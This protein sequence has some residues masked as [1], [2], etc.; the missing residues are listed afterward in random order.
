MRLLA[1]NFTSAATAAGPSIRQFF[2][3]Q[4]RAKQHPAAAQQ[5]AA[6]RQRTA[7]DSIGSGL[8][9]E[10]AAA[11][12]LAAAARDSRP[13]AAACGAAAPAQLMWDAEDGGYG[14]ASPVSTLTPPDEDCTQLVGD[15]ADQPLLALWQPAAALESLHAAAADAGGIRGGS[16]GGSD[17]AMANADSG[18][19]TATEVAPSASPEPS[20]Q[21]VDL[22]GIDVSEQRRILRQLQGGGGR[23]GGRDGK[24]S[25]P[26]RSSG[27]GGSGGSARRGV[28]QQGLMEAFRRAA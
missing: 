11:P 27:S 8:V 19:A 12:A 22:A 2:T 21:A 25:G 3:K 1:T 28:R 15:L 4:P 13:A 18:A 23:G 16:S 14:S 9:G 5:P 6:K 17:G 7:A 26:G 20:G 24:R 10:V